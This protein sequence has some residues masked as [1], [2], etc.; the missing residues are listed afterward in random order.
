M[1]ARSKSSKLWGILILVTLMMTYILPI[2]LYAFDIIREGTSPSFEVIDRSSGLSNLSVSSMI[3]DKDGFIWFGTQGGLNRYDG[4]HFK[5][6]TNN[7]Y[8]ADGLNHNLI[9]T[10]FYD[11]VEH[12]IWIGTYQ[13]VSRFDIASDTFKHFTVDESGL[14]NPVVVAIEKDA[15]GFI[16]VGTLDGLNK[17][18]LATDKIGRAHV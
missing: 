7:P 14:S 9:Q 5:T 2:P 6:Y 16:W 1:Y 8:D 10:M 4:R 12:V 13:G 15:E 3:Q 18:D 17:I 11:E